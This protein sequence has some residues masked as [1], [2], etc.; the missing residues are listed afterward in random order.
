M[1]LGAQLG[2]CCGGRVEIQMDL[3]T[4]YDALQ[5]SLEL[6]KNWQ[7][8]TIF[9]A[10]HVALALARQ[11]LL[12]QF[13]IY[14]KD[15]RD[16]TDW[17]LDPDLQL[18]FTDRLYYEQVQPIEDAVADIPAQSQVLILTHNHAEDFAIL[19]ACLLRQKKQ[20][21][22]ASIGLIG[23]AS[24]WASFHSRLLSMGFT[25]AEIQWVKCPIG[26]S[27]IKGKEPAVIALSVAADWLSN[28][29]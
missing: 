1:I 7:D 14:C 13:Q 12:L 28:K 3:L 27:S 4:A 23:S 15:S 2:Q 6:Q 8:V 16:P 18:N 5:H 17:Q 25:Q 20:A 11:L 21:D 24:K 26:I 9:G 19:K 22:L 10:G 29:S